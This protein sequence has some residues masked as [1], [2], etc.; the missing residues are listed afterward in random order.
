MKNISAQRTKEIL[1]K[2]QRIWRRK[3]FRFNSIA[4]EMIGRKSAYLLWRTTDGWWK[5]FR[6]RWIRIRIDRD[7]IPNRQDATHKWKI[8]KRSPEKKSS[9]NCNGT[10]VMVAY[11]HTPNRNKDLEPKLKRC[12]IEPLCARTRWNIFLG[13]EF[14]VTPVVTWLKICQRSSSTK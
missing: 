1:L 5:V 11:T 10:W 7:S 13:T 9:L 4:S 14:L 3:V 2:D 8:W 6:R 12:D